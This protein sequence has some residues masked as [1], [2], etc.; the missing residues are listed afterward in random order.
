MGDVTVQS[1]ILDRWQGSGT[2]FELRI[3]CNQT[4]FNQDNEGILQGNDDEDFFLRVPVVVGTACDDD[5]DTVLRFDE[6]VLDSTTDGTPAGSSFQYVLFKDGQPVKTVHYAVEV[7]PTNPVTTLS[8]LVIYTENKKRL[9]ACTEADPSLVTWDQLNQLLGQMSNAALSATPL[10]RG[11]VYMSDD[12]LVP[13]HPIAIEQYDPKWRGL[14]KAYQMEEFSDLL[15]AKTKINL[16]TTTDPAELVITCPITHSG[17][18]IDMG[19]NIIV[20]FAAAGLLTVNAG[21]TVKLKI[22]PTLLRQCFAGAGKALVK[23][24]YELW[25]DWYTDPAAVDHRHAMAQALES[26]T[27]TGSGGT[28][29]IGLGIWYIGGHEK[30]SSTQI[31]GSGRALNNALYGEVGIT[32]GTTLFV[33]EDETFG[34]QYVATAGDAGFFGHPHNNS[35]SNLNMIAPDDPAICCVKAEWSFGQVGMYMIDIHDCHFVGRATTAGQTLI[36]FDGTPPDGFPHWEMGSLLIERNWF[37]LGPGGGRSFYFNTTNGE[38][39]FIQNRFQGGSPGVIDDAV[40][41]HLGYFANVYMNTN[42]FAGPGGGNYAVV[43]TPDGAHADVTFSKFTGYD[44]VDGCI[45]DDIHSQVVIND[46][47]VWTRNDLGKRVNKAGVFEDAYITQIIDEKTAVLSWHP[48]NYAGLANV[49]VT[50]KKFV[51]HPN[52]GGTCVKIEGYG[53]QLTI[54]NQVDEGLNNSVDVYGPQYF[55]QINLQG[56]SFQ[57]R[58]PVRFGDANIRHDRCTFP[59][60]AFEDL[61]EEADIIVTGDSYIFA[62]TVFHGV[63]LDNSEKW[64]VRK[65]TTRE[66]FDSSVHEYWR[67]E[68]APLTRV[69]IFKKPAYFREGLKIRDT[70]YN[71]AVTTGAISVGGNIDGKNLI[72]WGK[73]HPVRPEELLYKYMLSMDYESGACNFDGNQAVFKKLNMNVPFYFKQNSEVSSGANLYT[74]AGANQYIEGYV[75]ATQK[76]STSGIGIAA[77]ATTTGVFQGTNRSTAVTGNGQLVYIGLRGDS[78]AAGAKAEFTFNNNCIKAGDIV[79]PFIHSGDTGGDLSVTPAG[80]VAD[81]SCLIRVRNEGAGASVNGPVIKVLIIKGNV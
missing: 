71:E 15:D 29:A 77:G 67:G 14:S 51:N 59:S 57:G 64:N 4:F 63:S 35:I 36:S 65:E 8:D 32:E 72:E 11:T 18:D 42:N 20:R 79:Y 47:D 16:A 48:T 56:S 34:F 49:P 38:C 50:V 76:N 40:H 74:K 80:D 21:L 60:L 2:G 26:C 53:N 25:L 37:T 54:V 39:R 23:N 66:P 44:D 10:V 5:P 1:G 9:G 17:A 81:G 73:Q 41:V 28:I 27:T 33:H 30:H 13:S 68:S 69:Q 31:R 22:G 70:N 43:D 46:D 58:L 55:S 12:A 24:P 3:F 7:P 78:L 6:H 75:L 61:S 19:D 52:I 62:Q 45:V